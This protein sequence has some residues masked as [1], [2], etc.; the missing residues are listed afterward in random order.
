MELIN[1]QTVVTAPYLT[2]FSCSN[3]SDHPVT[4]T[5]QHLVISFGTN[6][7]TLADLFELQGIHLTFDGRSIV[8]NDGTILVSEGSPFFSLAQYCQ[9]CGQPVNMANL[10]LWHS[11]VD[12]SLKGRTPDTGIE[13]KRTY[14]SHPVVPDG[15]FGPNWFHNWETRLVATTSVENPDIAWID[16]TGGAWIFKRNEEGTF[17][18]PPGFFGKLVESAH[19][20]VLEQPKG[21][22]F[23]FNKDQTGIPAGR[24]T[25]VKER[26]GETV[27]L[28]YDEK[29]FLFEVT[30][31]LA[32]TIRFSRSMSGKITGVLRVRDN[33]NYAYGYDDKLRLISSSDFD[34]NTTT[35]GYVSD[36]TGTRA[37]YLLSFIRDPLG[38]IS[39]N[40]YDSATGL[41]SSQTEPG[42]AQR[43]FWHSMSVDGSPITFMTDIDGAFETYNFDSKLLLRE[44][45]RADGA[46][47]KY[48][49]TESNQLANSTDPLG[50]V[51]TFGYDSRGNPTSV[52]HPLD[53]RPA[54]IEYDGV[55]DQPVRSTPIVG[56]PTTFG[57]SSENGDV[58][59]IVRYSGNATLEESIAYDLFGNP[60][61]ISNGHGNYQNRF[62]ANGLPIEVFD[63]RNPER[64][65]FDARGRILVRAFSTG[66]R[67]SY[68]WDDHDRLVRMDDTHGPSEK[69][70]YDV[71]NRL[72]SKTITDGREI[73][74]TRY[75]WDDRDRLVSETDASGHRTQYQYDSPSPMNGGF[76][77][78]DRPVAK[79]DANGN[80]TR[81]DYD[82]RDRLS[83]VTDALGGETRFEY[84]LRGD[85][86]SVVDPLGKATNYDYDAN[87]RVTVRSRPSVQTDASGLTREI[88]EQ[89]RYGYDENGKVIHEER[90]SPGGDKAVIDSTYDSFDR[91]VRRVLKR[92]G[93]NGS[94]TTEDDSSFSYSSQLDARLITRASNAVAI[95]DFD[96]DSV[97]PFLVRSYSVHAA[98]RGNPLGLIE[99]NFSV[100]RGT[101]NEAESIV[102]E[103]GKS[104]FS[105]KYDAASRLLKLVSG[106]T[107]GASAGELGFSFAY[108]GFGR[109]KDQRSSNKYAQSFT[110]DRNNRLV[111][112][113]GFEPGRRLSERLEYDPAG[114]IV[115]N[116]REFGNFAYTYDAKNE[117]TSVDISGGGFLGRTFD[118]DF[119]YDGAG[120][121]TFASKDGGTAI[122]LNNQITKNAS[123]SFESDAD[124][125]GSISAIVDSGGRSKKKLAY[126]A[127]GR[128]VSYELV[129][130]S[131]WDGDSDDEDAVVT[132]AEYF[133]DALGRRVAKR[134]HEK[135]WEPCRSSRWS[136]K[137]RLVARE[138]VYTQ[139]FAH[140][141]DRDR[142]LLA[143]AG[144]GA[145]SIFL[146]GKGVDEHLGQISSRRKKSYLTDHLGS[147]LNTEMAGAYRAYGVFG[148]SSYP[149][150]ISSL[151]RRDE[152][153][154]YGFTGREYD[155]ETG[156]YYYRAR[157]YN[158]DTGR[159]LTKDP[160]GFAGR[161]INLYRYGK[162]SPLIYSDPTGLVCGLSASNQLG[163]AALLVIF[164]QG[165]YAYSAANV[166]NP[167]L[168]AAFSALGFAFTAGGAVLV[169]DA[170]YNYVSENF[171]NIQNFFDS[172]SFD[173]SYN[174]NEG[175]GL[176]SVEGSDDPSHMSFA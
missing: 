5:I 132:K 41:V 133:Y 106:N 89:T 101:T 122:F 104:I 148:T 78:L 1:P 81:Y 69:Y 62:D 175:S 139:S 169:G 170:L 99:G 51:T 97:P 65:E 34:G 88:T 38:R 85:M 142:I 25:A 54:T 18:S 124:G 117:L 164:G 56:A 87:G 64:R 16:Q 123:A 46:V 3:I 152:P 17:L 126:R 75:A 74:T 111:Q 145:V 136:R 80:T 119:R 28:V 10:T 83:R 96:Y 118:Q 135:G 98:V 166:Y 115:G 90:L 26:H 140:E 40:F 58:L 150:K 42:S 105:A 167:A 161:E 108:D 47:E 72:I 84:D 154:R 19:E 100:R 144:D 63:A 110:Y 43:Y 159:F 73:Q 143:R 95:L 35:Y 165:S 24:L 31:A 77:I 129:V 128:L 158:P 176:P 151:G 157:I 102:D 21:V 163:I 44:V 23:F 113:D 27:S 49:W 9:R 153:V 130:D 86:I 4:I 82:S 12:F 141:S 156:L 33:L 131:D 138:S 168:A 36:I 171:Q 68:S 147:V 67:L 6:L 127:D 13:F 20:Y 2:D 107:L 32:G 71:V 173:N 114:N 109:K 91:L 160:I 39:E 14:L 103:R 155:A 162:N 93:T 22:K 61:A 57:I 94:S 53:P 60:Q 50:F 76:R 55:F 11:L 45:H 146:D 120:N 8:T 79:I 137:R 116:R 59:S 70:E 112:V 29:G 149:E 92:V 174:Y 121:R 30:T 37:A 125:S 66:R 52:R 172:G 48:G 7:P 134:I 15:D